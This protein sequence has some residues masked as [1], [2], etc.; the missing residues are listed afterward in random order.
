MYFDKSVLSIGPIVHC[1]GRWRPVLQFLLHHLLV[2]PVGG[3][4]SVSAFSVFFIWAVSTEVGVVAMNAVFNLV[5][6][7]AWT[8][9]NIAS[10]ENYPTELRYAFT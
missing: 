6:N 4:L 5:V 7:A 2:L 1:P 3:A 9:L 8:A 10:V